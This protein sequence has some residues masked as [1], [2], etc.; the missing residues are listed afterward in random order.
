M[1]QLAAL[2]LGELD[3]EV[4]T[5]IYALIALHVAAL[6]RTRSHSLAYRLHDP[7]VSLF[8][9]RRPSGSYP[10]ASRNGRTPTW[11]E[12]VHALIIVAMHRAITRRM[13]GGHRRPGSAGIG[14]VLGRMAGWAPV[15]CLPLTLDQSRCRLGLG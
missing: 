14:R 1:S 15:N 6:V 11:I 7:R 4:K 5:I 10:A 2:S 3:A 8:L 12:R 13:G 9:I